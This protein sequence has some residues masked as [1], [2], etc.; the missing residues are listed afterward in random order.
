VR[1][2]PV[3]AISALRRVGAR[4]DVFFHFR[5]QVLTGPPCFRL[6]SSSRQVRPGCR[7]CSSED[8]LLAWRLISALFGCALLVLGAVFGCCYAKER[9]GA[10]LLAAFVASE[11]VLVVYSRTDLLDGILLF[12]ILATLLTALR[13]EWRGQISGRLCCLVSVLSASNGRNYLR[14]MFSGAKGCSDPSWADCGSR[15]SSSTF[16]WF[17]WEIAEGTRDP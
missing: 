17:T 11:T 9:V 3:C 5:L 4:R 14:V 6:A 8:M 15:T 1:F 12:F 16:S 2:G 10:L 13:A 7:H